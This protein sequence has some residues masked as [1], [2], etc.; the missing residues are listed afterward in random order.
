MGQSESSLSDETQLLH[1]FRIVTRVHHL[2]LLHLEHL[3][4][5][6]PY[7]LREQSFTEEK[8]QIDALTKLKMRQSWSS[9]HLT[10][11][12]SMSSITKNTNITN[13]KIC[14]P[15]TTTSTD[16]GSTPIEP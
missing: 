8:D 7:L 12:I 15:S 5:H 1:T 4:T 11:L 9:P 14:A 3:D 16:C 10:N 2:N 13:G 6:K